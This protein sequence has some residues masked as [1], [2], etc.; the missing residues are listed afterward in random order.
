MVYLGLEPRWSSDSQ[1]RMI[2]R[3]VKNGID[4]VIP[5]RILTDSDSQL[6]FGLFLTIFLLGSY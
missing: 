1:E 3:W 4:D 6:L 2:C 5:F